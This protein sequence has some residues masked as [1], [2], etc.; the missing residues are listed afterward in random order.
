MGR[1]S[2]ADKFMSLPHALLNITR[3]KQN[4]TLC[5]SKHNHSPSVK[6]ENDTPRTSSFSIAEIA[7]WALPPKSGL[8]QSELCVELPA[9]QRGAV[10]PAFK[11]EEL[12]DSLVR[13]FPIGCFILSEPRPHLGARKFRLQENANEAAPA[14]SG[15]HLLL[16]GQQRST[17]IA[18]AFLD[19][20][21]NSAD[22]NGKPEFVLWIDLEPP[23]PSAK[24]HHA[25]RL[26]TR[27]HP[28]GYQRANA[29]ERLSTSA[30][31]QAMLAY[32]QSAR[33][34]GMPSL[35]FRPGHLPL[36]FS[37][38]HDARAPVPMPLI[39]SAIRGL[40]PQTDDQAIWQAVQ[41]GVDVTP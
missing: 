37:W 10:W 29:A 19:P 34:A 27:S 17:A 9:L 7:A 16:D 3:S 18:T 39:L 20:W 41:Q 40:P 1:R 23:P 30:R 25:F 8:P 22:A 13:G 33:T 21:R 35:T 2:Y 15:G 5:P 26:L 11:V 32:E 12:W 28:W 38:P 31:R 4:L 14:R 24:S 36:E 6:R